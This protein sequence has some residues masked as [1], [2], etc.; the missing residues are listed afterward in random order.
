LDLFP[1]KIVDE[2]VVVDTGT[3][4]AREKFDSSQETRV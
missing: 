3:P 1:M 2:E 4:M